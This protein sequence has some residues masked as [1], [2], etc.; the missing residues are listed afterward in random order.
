MA[1]TFSKVTKDPF[2]GATRVRLVA[3]IIAVTFAVLGLI[4]AC[5][6]VPGL[7]S[8]PR[9]NSIMT[10]QPY[11]HNGTWVFDDVSA[12]LVQEPFVANVPKMIDFLVKDIPNSESGFRMLFSAREFPG[13][14]Y[15]LDWVEA[16]LGGNYYKLQEPEME[17]WVCPAMYKYF[18][19]PPPELYV[20]AEAIDR[21]Q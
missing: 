10:I 3:S 14:Q 17:G 6:L 5:G 15:R 19:T 4:W 9:T 11:R 2:L 18:E 13:Y 16:E 8:P 1:E 12:G 7:N 20:K 21:R